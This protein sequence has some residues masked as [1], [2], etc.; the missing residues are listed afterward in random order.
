MKA[1][2]REIYCVGN[3]LSASVLKPA[4]NNIGLAKCQGFPLIYMA[5]LIS[6]NVEL[7]RF[8]E[9]AEKLWFGA[10]VKRYLGRILEEREPRFK[11]SMAGKDYL[12]VARALKE[13]H[14]PTYLAETM[15]SM[16]M[17]ASKHGYSDKDYP[18]IAKY[19]IELAKNHHRK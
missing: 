5:L 12:Y 13:K 8:M 16:F 18:Q 10:I 3:I 11:V 14:M 6:W 9:V 15:S 19:Y 2:S 7:E 4:L 1:Y 17:K